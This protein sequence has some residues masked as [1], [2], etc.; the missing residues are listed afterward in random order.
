MLQLDRLANNDDIDDSNDKEIISWAAS[1]MHPET[2]DLHMST[3]VSR[4]IVWEAGHGQNS[5]EE[6]AKKGACLL[7]IEVPAEEDPL[8]LHATERMVGLA[9]ELM[10]VFHGA[11]N[12]QWHPS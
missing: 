5:V 7:Q 8:S 1:R 4:L 6:V 10:A 11:K 2:K 12:I 9:F 3:T